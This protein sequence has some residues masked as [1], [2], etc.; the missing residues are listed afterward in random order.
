M[1]LHSLRLREHIQNLVRDSM[2]VWCQSVIDATWGLH[3]FY[4]S[5]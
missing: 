2:I 3:L 5:G 1:N 4:Q